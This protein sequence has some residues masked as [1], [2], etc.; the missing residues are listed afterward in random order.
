M[1]S[2]ASRSAAQRLRQHKALSVA[3]Y[4]VASEKPVKR[5][6]RKKRKQEKWLGMEDKVFLFPTT[7]WASYLQ[8]CK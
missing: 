2:D 1:L 5:K 4:H 8:Y 7:P 3:P 6:Q